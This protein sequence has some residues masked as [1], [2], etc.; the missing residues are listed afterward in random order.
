MKRWL[1]VFLLTGSVLMWAQG[2]GG[3]R[4]GST[5]GGN[6]GIG[7]MGSG[8][9]MGSGSGNM[10]PG[11]SSAHPMDMDSMPWMVQRPMTQKQMNSGCFQML[12]Q[13]TGMTREQMQQMYTHSGA[14]DFKQF[15]SAV[16]ASQNLHLDTHQVMNGLK[17]MN[18]TQTLKSMGVPGPNAKAGV[19]K[20]EQQ[21]KQADKKKT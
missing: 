6:T 1:L 10:G 19:K 9:G 15:A 5:G 17:T 2:H 16:V 12:Q 18:L 21:V 8:Q 13:M 7:S 3:M 20:A 11:M 4:G 14:Q